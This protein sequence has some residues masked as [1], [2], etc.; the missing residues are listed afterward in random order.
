MARLYLHLPPEIAAK[1]TAV[2][3]FVVVLCAGVSPYQLNVALRRGRDLLVLI[4]RARYAHIVSLNP[5]AG[6]SQTSEGHHLPAATLRLNGFFYFGYTF[7][8]LQA[9][10]GKN[11]SKEGHLK[12]SKWPEFS[13]D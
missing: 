11:S 4:K 10:R 1:T 7:R 9:E 6:P 8:P 5:V 13:L 2:L 3:A 12:V